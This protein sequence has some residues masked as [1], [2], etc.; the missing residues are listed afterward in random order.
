MRKNLPSTCHHC[1]SANLK[2][3][4]TQTIDVG[5][6]PG[7]PCESE[8]TCNDCKRSVGYWAYGEFLPDESY[9]EG[10]DFS[11]LTQG[12]VRNLVKDAGCKTLGELKEKRTP[13]VSE[14]WGTW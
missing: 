5:V 13:V 8:F 1:G 14:Q 3:R 12:E 4:P 6:G 9:P 10:L 7:I 2:E 11:D